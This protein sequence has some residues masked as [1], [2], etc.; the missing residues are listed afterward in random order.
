[1]KEFQGLKL[2]RFQEEA[3]HSIENNHSVVV[4]A[5]TGTGKTLIADYLIDKYLK[6]GKKIVYTA[7]IKALSNQK[8]SDFKRQYGEEKVGI[9]TGDVTINHNAPLRIMTTEIYRNML[10]SHDPEL[11]DVMYIVFDEIHY[12]GDFERGTVWE[13]SIIFSKEHTRF[14]CLSATIPNAKQFAN[15]ISYIKKHQVDV[16]LEKKRAVPLKQSFYDTETGFCELKEIKELK[17][18]DKHPKYKYNRRRFFDELKR[19]KRLGHLDLLSEMKDKLPAIYF[20]FS[21]METQNKAVILAKKNNYLTSNEQSQLS[22]IVRERLKTTDESVLH[23]DSTKMLRECLSKGIGFHNAGVLPVL[24]EIVETLFSQGLIK[25]LFA[26][27]T[28][29]VGINMP[30]KTV[31]FDSMEKFDG[32]NFRYLKSKEFFQLAGRAGRRGIDK[33]GFV[34]VVIERRTMDINHVE[35]IVQDDKESLQ[36]QFKLSFNTILNLIHRHTEKEQQVILESN[37]YTYQQAGRGGANRI[38]ASFEK[39]KKKLIKEGYIV[40]GLNDLELTEKGLFSMRIYSNELLVGELFTGRFSQ[41]FTNKEILL[42]VG[43]IS[44]EERKNHKFKSKK[45]DISNAA[46]KK[47][48]D[49][50][51]LYNYFRKNQLYLLEQFLVEWYDGCDFP[52]LLELSNLSEG[53]I[54]RY[55][56]Q[57][58]D[59]LQQIQHATLSDDLKNKIRDIVTKIDRDVVSVRF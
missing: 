21:R 7:P 50:A 2:D 27:E 51:V 28:F 43:R 15:W 36:S 54:V 22:S 8:Y 4:S 30:A 17:K 19:T 18:L 5:A 16:V 33:V 26:T 10:L 24:K 31:V 44:Y 38:K 3:I 56:R 45:R 57:I 1:M 12:L 52:D 49:N 42:L 48:K 34:V 58:I 23:L 6:Q 53:D 37:F 35:R 9:L 14:L 20:C 32:I 41:L 40:H 25:V 29:A 11:D 47:I 13:E 59:L 46:F 39:K 55:I